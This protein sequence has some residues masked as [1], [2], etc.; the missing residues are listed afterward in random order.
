MLDK[1][2]AWL[3]F[4]SFGSWMTF[5]CSGSDVHVPTSSEG[6]ELGTGNVGAACTVPEGGDGTDTTECPYYACYCRGGT[7][8]ILCTDY[9]KANTAGSSEGTCQNAD[10]ACAFQCRVAGAVLDHVGPATHAVC[11]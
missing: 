6:S 9:C 10:T 3:V 2:F 4:A 11:D 7:E 8:P 5:A 1:T